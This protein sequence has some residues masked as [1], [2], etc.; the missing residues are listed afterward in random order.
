[1]S[2]VAASRTCRSIGNVCV[3][4]PEDLVGRTLYVQ[5]YGAV[6]TGAAASLAIITPVEGP[7]TTNV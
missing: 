3:T 7:A 4:L 5:V 6:P 1:L 2:L